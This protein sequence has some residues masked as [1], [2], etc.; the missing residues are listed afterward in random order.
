[1]TAVQC[2]FDGVEQNA[3]EDTS[4]SRLQLLTH[5]HDFNLRHGSGGPLSRVG[6][7]DRAVR[8]LEQ[9]DAPAARCSKCHHVRCSAAKDDRGAGQDSAVAVVVVDT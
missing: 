2:A 9:L 6:P 1:M 4:I 3:A 8:Q 7:P 5:V